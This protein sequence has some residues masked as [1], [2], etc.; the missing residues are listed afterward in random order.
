[1]AVGMAQAKAPVENLLALPKHAVDLATEIVIR[2][3]GLRNLGEGHGPFARL[4]AE[5]TVHGRRPMHMPAGEVP[6]PHATAGQGVDDLAREAVILPRGSLRQIPER[7][8]EQRQHQRAADQDGDLQTCVAPPVGKDHGGRLQERDL[9]VGV[10][11]V[12][13]GDDGVGAVGERQTQDACI[14]TEGG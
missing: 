11:D 3:Q 4:L 14:L 2:V 7:A 8:A 13:D 5:Q 1:M 10:G 12:A 9:D 6:P